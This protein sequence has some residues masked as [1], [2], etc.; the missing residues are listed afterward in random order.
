MGESTE[1][2]GINTP[3]W[4]LI[5]LPLGFAAPLWGGVRLLRG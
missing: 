4:E 1:A 5:H 3:L 2:I